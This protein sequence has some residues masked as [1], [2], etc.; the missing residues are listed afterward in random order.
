MDLILSGIALLLLLP[1]WRNIVKRSLLDTHRDKLF[2]L[3]DELRGK[4][5]SA[6][7]DMNSQ[8]YRQL[9]DILNG[10]LRYTESFQF[11]EF[12]FIES[13]IRQNPD[14]Q[15]TMKAKF[16]EAFI[17]LEEDQRRFAIKLRSEARRV[18]MSHMI[19]SSFPLV[20]MTLALF[21][22]VAAYVAGLAII[23]RISSTGSL[24]TQS[25]REFT[26]LIS[27]FGK[28][29]IARIARAVLVEDLVEEYSYRQAFQS[30]LT[31]SRP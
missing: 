14:L 15:A 24:F 3:R 20:V 1:V 18:M 29:V 22:I 30:H 8:V 7:W 19:L 13:R 2:D 25:A 16:E 23:R 4:F 11:S 26:E 28:V 5:H 10:Y 31:G 12:S 17:D 21:P 27:A 6:Q 9:R